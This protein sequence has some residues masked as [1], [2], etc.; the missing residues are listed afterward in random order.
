ML[1]TKLMQKN[2]DFVCINC[3]FKCSK[4]SN[5]LLHVNTKKHIHRLVGNGMETEIMPTFQCNCGKNY[6]SKSG[7]WKHKKICSSI[8]H[9]LQSEIKKPDLV[10]ILLNQN[11]ELIK[12]NQEFKDLLTEQS[13]MMFEQNK[14]MANIAGKVGN[15][16]NTNCHNTNNTNNFNLQFFLNEQ[17]KDALNIMDFINQLQLKLT[18]LDMVGKLGY[19]E[20]ISKIFIREL[21][22]LDVF[23]RPIHCSDLKR[24]VMYVKDKDSWEKDGEEKKKMKTAIKYIAAKNFKQIGEWQEENPESDDYESKKHMEYHNIIINAMGGS[25]E[26]EEEKYYNKIIKNVSK[27]VIIDKTN[28]QQ[29]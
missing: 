25:T 9:E 18:D 8:N 13:K 6:T 7:L 22:E 15:T 27:E 16:T 26:D 21:K 29:N 19:S 3:D 2:A 14:N 20:G 1:E 23:K 11:M 17:C 12:Q 24:E 5:W 28:V 10:E 4:K